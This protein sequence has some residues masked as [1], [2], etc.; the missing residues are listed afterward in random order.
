MSLEKMREQFKKEADRMRQERLA[1][2]TSKMINEKLLQANQA[3]VV[4]HLYGPEG[5]ILRDDQ[6]PILGYKSWSLPL[7]L[8]VSMNELIKMYQGSS[9]GAEY[10][11]LTWV[12]V[13]STA[14]ETRRFFGVEKPTDR[15][16]V[17]IGTK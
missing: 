3:P 15:L 14:M 10:G 13:P 2:L 5:C 6:L 12:E 17:M 11:Q 1:E 7:P 16:F 9:V 4:F 8:D